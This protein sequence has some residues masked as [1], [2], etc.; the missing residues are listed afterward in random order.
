VN[1][2]RQIPSILCNKPNQEKQALEEA[3]M[4]KILDPI[5]RLFS[6]IQP[7]PSG[8]YHYQS[9]ANDPRNYRIHLRLEVDG[10]GI[11]IV[12]AATVLH[13]NQTAAEYAYYL[14]QNL[15]A[16]TV[17]DKIAQRY[18]IDR[19]TAK[20]DY[21]TFTDR[22]QSLVNTPDLDPI[23][24]L[25]FERRTPYSGQ[26]SAPYRLDCALTYRTSQTENLEAAPLERVE[27]EL[28]SAEWIQII[29]KAWEIGIPHIIFTGGEPTLREDL[30]ELIAAAEANGQV[31]G[32]LSDGVKL[33]N[34]AY[35]QKLLQTGLDHL[36]IIL[37]P[38]KE[39]V[40][41][42]LEEAL[43]EDIFVAVHLTLSEPQIEGDLA[44]LER[45]AM[46]GVK[47]ISVSATSKELAPQLEQVRQKIADLQLDLVWNLPTPYSA[48]HP[49]A[50]ETSSSEIPQ[51][52]GTAFL[53]LEPDGD[54]LPAQ[55][56]NQVMG[57]FLNDH[58][59]SLR[60]TAI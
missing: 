19:A 7:L 53:Y 2:Y 34:K 48:T 5:R 59:E 45:L 31:T 30:P 21:Q 51:G 36:M 58:W 39:I 13:L 28:S 11:L 32:L 26:I 29:Q 46:L 42:A 27:R 40:W 25:D 4:T 17:A 20:A 44:L 15:D 57:N 3:K 50:L 56:V 24:F 55:G 9:P 47:A 8:M 60:K 52:A 38:K 54:A 23:T 16:E 1:F 14:V 35:L 6:G 41:Q 33:A 10:S 22:I 49:V 18:R 37:D 12:N 43:A